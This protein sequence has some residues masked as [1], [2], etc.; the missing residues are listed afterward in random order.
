MTDIQ[1]AH[2]LQAMGLH[3][4]DADSKRV[5]NFFRVPPLGYKLEYLSLAEC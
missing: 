2:Q 1:P 5:R 3:R 4:L